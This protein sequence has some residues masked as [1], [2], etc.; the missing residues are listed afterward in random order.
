LIDAGAEVL[1][2][3]GSGEAAFLLDGMYEQAGCTMVSGAAALYKQSDVIL[4]L[5]RPI[6]NEALGKDE[7]DMM[8]EGQVLIALLQPLVNK[9]LVKKLAQKKITSFSMDAIPRIAR[10]QRMDALSSQSSIA[11]YKAVLIGASKLGKYLPMMMT[12]AATMPPAKVLILGAGVAGLQA[13]A[14]AHRLGAQVEAFDVRPAVKEQVESLG[15]TFI[16]VEE[17]AEEAEDTGG[18]AK[19]LSED[20]QQKERE[21]IQKHVEGADIVITTALVPGR[22]APILVTKEMVAG[23]RAGSVIVDLAA[24]TGGNCELTEPGQETV[25]NGIIIVGPINLSSDMAMQAS[26][27]YSR[28]I[29]GLLLLM[30]QEGKLDFNFEDVIINDCCVTHQGEVRGVYKE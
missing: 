22:A 15:A 10:A 29:S 7:L 11:G 5:Q 25:K 20:A 1:V 18:Y 14:T 12:A 28:N 2:E 19:E 21:L 3:K 24:E 8:K 17:V 30:L 9:D 16:E 4:K 23:M 6:K 26:Q 27:L 13:I